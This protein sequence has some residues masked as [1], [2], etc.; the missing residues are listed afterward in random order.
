MGIATGDLVV[1]TI[2]SP[3]AQSFTV[4]GDTVNLASRL[5]GANKAYRTSILVNEEAYRLAQHEIEARELDFITVVGKAEPVR[6][7]EVM[8][9]T[10]S[11]SSE[12]QEL[13]GLF[14]EGLAA[15]RER[16]WDRAEKKFAKCLSVVATDAPAIIFSERVAALREQ[17]LS[18]NW[19][20]VWHLA[21]K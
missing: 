14:A 4:I 2:G 9:V 1:G 3:N 12:Q 17:S 11:L 18:A 21:E 5:E 8:G 10:G 6:I 16:D 19:D 7:Y 20:G 15:Y 13:R